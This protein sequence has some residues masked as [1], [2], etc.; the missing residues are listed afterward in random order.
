MAEREN[1][2][3]EGSITKALFIIALPI[4]ISNILQ[5]VLE[6]VDMYFI[7]HLG[8]DAIAGGTMS[9]SIIM[10]LTTVMFGVVTATAAFISRAYGSKQYERIQVILAHA[11]Y[12]ALIISAI[13]AVIG[14]FWSEE[15][16]LLMG[17]EPGALAEGA[18]FLRPMLMGLFGMIILMTLVTAFQSSGDSRTPMYVMI[19]V[20]IVNIILNPTLIQGLAGLPAFGIAGS[21][22]A[23]ILSRTAGIVLL[24][25]VMYLHPA[26]KN[27]PVRLLV[28]LTF[29]PQ[30]VKNIIVIA[31][32][33]ALQSGIRSFGFLMMTSLITIG[34]GT[35]AVAAYGIAIRLDML[36]FIIVMGL[37]TAIAVMVGQNLGAGKVERA[38]MAVK[39]AVILNAIF[40]ACVAVFY[41]LNAE[42]LLA[43]FGA[44]GETLKDGVIFMHIVPFS[45]FISA[46]A[47]TLGFAMNGAGMTRPG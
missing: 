15:L 2:V 37:C 36:G 46:A 34:Y 13:I 31:I 29:E 8:D 1:I 6:V 20:N 45:Y 10:V 47:M 41:Y 3:T 43:F 39:Y 24:L 9:L 26:F 17:A 32:P 21:A 44:E 11:L 5:S 27:S 12:L 4:I 16:L 7:G 33:S 35:V 42:M 19:A 18:K 38:E 23:S 25:G 22:Y 28:K 40:M 30:L 14:L